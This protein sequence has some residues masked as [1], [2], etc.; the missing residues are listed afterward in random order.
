MTRPLHHIGYWVSDLDTAVEHAVR[1]LGVGPFLVDRHVRFASFT[2]ADGTEIADP[3]YLDH[4]AAFAA[5]GPIVLELAQVHSVHPELAAAYRIRTGDV[6]H[7]SWVVEDLPAE[8][9]RLQALGCPLI[10]TA[11]LGQVNVAWH[12]G[13]SLFPHPIEVHR[14]GAP[15]LGMHARLSALADGWDGADVMRPIAP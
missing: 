9:A 1:T 2:L 10:H 5:W 7:V 14:A 6:G 15:I 8:S 12:D 13:G 3:A 11:N 4:T